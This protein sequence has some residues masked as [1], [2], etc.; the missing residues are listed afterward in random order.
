MKS[1]QTKKIRPFLDISI[2]VFIVLF[3]IVLLKLLHQLPMNTDVKR[4]GSGRDWAQQHVEFKLIF[5]P[6]FSIEK[7]FLFSLHHKTVGCCNKMVATFLKRQMIF[8]GEIIITI[9]STFQCIV[10][11]IYSV[12]ITTNAQFDIF[13]LQSCLFNERNRVKFFENQPFIKLQKSIVVFFLHL[14][15]L[16]VTA[17]V[18]P[19][20]LGT[21]ILIC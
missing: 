1:M 21:F 8:S 14:C 18:K 19:S 7:Q 16:T 6:I 3:C 17:L 4:Y 13:M 11:Y 12:S 15:Y 5:F 20:R 2:I 10:Y 9:I